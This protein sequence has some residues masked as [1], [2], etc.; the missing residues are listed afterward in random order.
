MFVEGTR[1]EIYWIALAQSTELNGETPWLLGEAA[2]GKPT[3]RRGALKSVRCS[4]RD[5]SLQATTGRQKGLVHAELLSFHDQIEGANNQ[6]E[7]WE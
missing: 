5:D 1:R 3:P 4:L 2:A 6:F 7:T